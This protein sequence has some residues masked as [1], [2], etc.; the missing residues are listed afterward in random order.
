MRVSCFSYFTLVVR[1]ILKLAKKTDEHKGSTVSCLCWNS[2]STKLFIGDNTGRVTGLE[3]STGKVS[4]PGLIVA[5]ETF[6][7]GSVL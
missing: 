7:V 2:S 5:V 4:C 1:P 6:I 3:V